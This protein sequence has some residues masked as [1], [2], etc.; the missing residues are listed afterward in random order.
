MEDN[1]S[2]YQKTWVRALLIALGLVFVI[3]VYFAR[4]TFVFY[5]AL[6]S[7]EQPVLNTGPSKTYSGILNQSDTML[8]LNIDQI[9][10]VVAGRGDDPFMGPASATHVVVQFID[11]GCPYC[12][13]SA[14]TVR[15]LAR[16]RPDVKIII[17]DFPVVELDPEAENA[18][19]AARCVWRYAGDAA[20]W[21]Y[22]DM[23][24]ASQDSLSVDLMIMLAKNLGLD[25]RF[26]AC[27]KSKLTKPAVDRSLSDAQTSGVSVTPTFFIDGKRIDGAADLQ[28]ILNAIGD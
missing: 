21:R 1:R 20:F 22:H 18:A 8:G 13:I 2:W 4:Q 5:Q 26:D 14:G 25:S 15:D 16:L 3:L 27:L 9:K 10:T 23:L 19:V 12:K 28:T 24:Y 11:Y 17:R 6:K 7:G